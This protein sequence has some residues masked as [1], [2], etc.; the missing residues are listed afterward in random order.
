LQKW[1]GYWNKASLEATGGYKIADFWV[2]HISTRSAAIAAL[3]AGMVQ[4]LDSQYQ[5]QKDASQ[6]DPAWSD[7]A[8]YLA[9]HVQE[10]GFNMKHPILGTGTDTPLGQAYPARAAE[11]ALHVRR[12][13]ECLTPKDYIIKT[14]LAGYGSAGLTTSV[15]PQMNGGA[16]YNNAISVRN[17]TDTTLAKYT[18]MEEL[19][20]AGYNFVPVTPR[21][22]FDTYGLLLS[23][24]ELGV[25]AVLA[26]Y[27]IHR[28]RPPIERV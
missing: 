27:I 2:R 15:L 10:L 3:K 17:I 16:A 23:A 6:L 21:S 24:V 14:L 4:V 18:A 11:A 26:G 22:F 13:I 7:N 25:V 20:A 9:W 5:L 12:A 19:K 28:L 8:S 1:D